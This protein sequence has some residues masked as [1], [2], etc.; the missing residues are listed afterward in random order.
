MQEKNL[1]KISVS[2]FAMD[3]LK[4]MAT[5]KN[6]IKPALSESTLANN[7]IPD[8]S[9]IKVPASFVN[10][11]TNNKVTPVK[12]IKENLT[13]INEIKERKLENLITKFSNLILEARNVMKEIS[14]MGKKL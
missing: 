4:E 3:I 11:V 14:G 5:N 6:S 7:G 1:P 8:L 2:D 9:K 10:L 12:I 13:S